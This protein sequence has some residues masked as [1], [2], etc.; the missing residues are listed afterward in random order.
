MRLHPISIISRIRTAPYAAASFPKQKETHQQPMRKKKKKK[1][2]KT[3]RED[4]LIGEY[5]HNLT[6]TVNSDVRL[7]VLAHTV[8]SRRKQLDH[9]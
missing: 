3:T 6:T 2:P 8:R 7:F 1:K 4:I 5:I 9:D